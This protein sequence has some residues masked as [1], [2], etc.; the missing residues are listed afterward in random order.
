MSDCLCGCGTLTRGRR[1]F[2]DKA[3][4]LAWMRAGGARQIGALQPPEARQRGGQVGGQLAADSGRLVAASALGIARIRAVVE[5]MSPDMSPE[6]RRTP[7]TQ[8]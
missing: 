2:V 8:P 3:H 1:V 5:G 4:Q 6:P 7:H